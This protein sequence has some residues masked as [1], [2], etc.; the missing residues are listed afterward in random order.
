[1]SL[2]HM[3]QVLIGF[4]LALIVITGI[5]TVK[6]LTGKLRWVFVA[7]A[8]MDL[9]WGLAVI[10]NYPGQM[11]FW[12]WFLDSSAEGNGI[13]ITMSAQL[14]AIGWTALLL[15]WRGQPPNHWQR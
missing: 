2:A 14:M 1:M 8:G 9:F 13:A 12:G 6:I 4:S 5:P 11:N 7:L 3:R 10:L 15:A